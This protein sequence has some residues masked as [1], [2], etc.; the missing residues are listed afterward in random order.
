MIKTIIFDYGGVLADEGFRDGL[1]A[2]AE[3]NG[4]D[5]E[6][7]FRTA[8]DL[9][10]ETG[11]VTGTADETTYL[12]ALREK[13]GIRESNGTIRDEL[14]TRFVLRRDVMEYV[15]SL[16]AEGLGTAILSDQ[17]DWLDELDKK[18][19]FFNHFDH[20]FN[21]FRIGKGKRD[22]SVFAD[23]CLKIG[24][25]P[26]ETVFVDDNIDNINRAS[27]EGLNAVLYTD[28]GE[29][30]AHLKKYLAHDRPNAAP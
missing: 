18:S 24:L 3:H 11:Y 13:T 16:R 22:P 28:L 8:A 14:L 20:V 30:K 5:P 6:E 9:I 27:K 2:I 17:T 23:V 25:Q 7:F 12:N 10:Y 21:S 26:G 4:L 29:L 15:R 19:P 1:K